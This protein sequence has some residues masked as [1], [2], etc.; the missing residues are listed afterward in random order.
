MLFYALLLALSLFILSYKKKNPRNGILQAA[1][2]SAYTTYLVWSALTSQPF[3]MGCSRP[4]WNLNTG[5]NDDGLSL[6]IGVIFTFLALIYSALRVSTSS[7][8]LSPKEERRQKKKLLATLA[9]EDEQPNP[10]TKEIPLKD[11]TSNNEPPE[12]PDASESDN[13]ENED[14]PEGPV[15]Y[16]YSFFHF[17][18]LLATMYLGMVLTNWQSISIV[19]GQGV[20]DNTILIDQGMSAVWVKVISS[21][22]T[23][24]LF[25][26]TMIAPVLFPNRKF[27]EEF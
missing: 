20:S 15:A 7:E 1:V 4:L 3:S 19:T 9:H 12:S 27:F 26:W 6:I 16:N 24:L 25:L 2:V 13:E 14:D 11:P 8:S 23:M 17:T 22:V 10:N 5:T 18:F 21:W